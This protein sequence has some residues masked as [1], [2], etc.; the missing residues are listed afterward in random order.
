MSSEGKFQPIHFTALGFGLAV[1]CGMVYNAV[2]QQ[3]SGESFVL[4][5]DKIVQASD[6]STHVNN[7]SSL[8]HSEPEPHVSAIAPETKPVPE[9]ENIQKVQ[10]GKD[11]GFIEEIVACISRI[12][13]V[14][15]LIDAYCIDAILFDDI[16]KCVEKSSKALKILDQSWSASRRGPVTCND[17][18]HYFLMIKS[19]FGQG[20]LHA[21]LKA[22]EDGVDVD[23][24]SDQS[25]GGN[26][27]GASGHDVDRQDLPSSWLPVL[28]TRIA[29]IFRRIDLNGDHYIDKEEILALHGGDRSTTEAMF[30]DLDTN[31]DGRISPQEFVE[32][33]LRV[34]RRCEEKDKKTN[35]PMR[36]NALGNLERGSPT[37]PSKGQGLKLGASITKG[38]KMVNKIASILE[39]KL[40]DRDERIHY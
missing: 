33:F 24:F 28:S 2:T 6:A 39:Q 36:V 38:R 13:K 30:A 26:A 40:T 12:C 16:C 7:N 5:Q 20:F 15:S 10:G 27:E 1:A 14:Y 32:Y 31:R 23:P 22:F 25:N 8:H 29:S 9:E 37:M 18:L 35:S 19:E 21:H 17:F 11:E 3:K 34:L 4:A